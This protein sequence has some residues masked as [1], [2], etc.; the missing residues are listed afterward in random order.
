MK[1]ARDVPD[2]MPIAIA[3]QREDRERRQ[4]RRAAGDE[5]EP[6]EWVCSCFDPC[7]C[8]AGLVNY[9]WHDNRHVLLQAVGGERNDELL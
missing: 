5:G 4:I 8:A 3:V 7:V 9:V 6:I 1:R 2:V